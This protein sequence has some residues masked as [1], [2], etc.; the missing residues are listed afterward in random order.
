MANKTKTMDGIPV[1]QIE[2]FDGIHYTPPKTGISEWGPSRTQQ[3]FKDEVDTNKIITRYQQ[4]G[5]IR[6]DARKAMYGDFTN[7]TNFNDAM[8]QLAYAQQA[9]DQL[10]AAIRDRFNNDPAQMLRFLDDPTQRDEAVRLG[11][12]VAPTP[13]K[14]PPPAPAQGSGSDPQA[15]GSLPPAM[16]QKEPAKAGA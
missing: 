16:V 6:I 12:A 13:A 3:Q 9:F 11:L 5:Q 10:P 14:A 1:Q 4:T 7:V 2:I 15:G 8:N